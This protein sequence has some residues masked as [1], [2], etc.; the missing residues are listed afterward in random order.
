MARRAGLVAYRAVSDLAGKG[1]LFIVTIVA[2]RRLSTDG[3]G[4]FAL[5]STLGWTLAV[6]TDCGIQM[7]LARVVA[8]QPADALR[9]LG[10]WLHVRLATAAAALLVVAFGLVIARPHGEAAAGIVLFAATYVVSGLVELLHYFYRGLGRSDVESSLTVWQRSLTLGCALAVLAWRPNLVLLGTALLVPVVVTLATSLW[11]APR[12]GRGTSPGA[13]EP[14]HGVAAEPLGVE[15]WRDV[16]PIGI[17][18]VLSALYFRV[19][20]FLVQFWRGTEAVALY[21]AVFRLVEALRLFPAAV[22]AVALPALCRSDDA[23]PVRRVSFAVT[24]F[25]VLVTAAVWPLAGWAI[26]FVYGPDYGGA[27]PAFRILLLAFPLL[28]LNYALTYQLIAW[29]GQRAYAAICGVALVANVAMNAAL[30]PAR[31]IEGAAWTTLWTEALLTAMCAL[32][33][34][35]RRARLPREIAPAGAGV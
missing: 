16:L 9:V 27:V 18:T 28:S 30:I 15:L 10:R 7:H 8:R 21:N 25:A 12:I 29:D 32:A 13:A 17:G 2:A 14:S 4:I 20:V 6:A 35:A 5:A 34:R 31:S 1:S 26:P 19:D 11:I 23:G 3:F 22:L 24:L 33:L